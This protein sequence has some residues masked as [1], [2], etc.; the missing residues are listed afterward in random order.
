MRSA[1]ELAVLACVLVLA[2]AACSPLTVLNG[3]VPDHASRIVPDVAYGE[4]GRRL[5]DIYAP[6]GVDKPPVVVF[7]YGGSWRNGSRADYK[8]VGDAL[9][10]RGIMAVIA[11]YR[12]YPAVSYPD[13]VE[14]SARAVAW[15][16]QHIAEYGGDPAR[17]YVA[18]HSA[19]GY[20]AAMVALDARWL[21]RFGASPAMLRGWIGMA[22]PYDFLPIVAR[23]VKPVFHFPG[24]PPDS[25]PIAHV[26]AAAPPTLLMAGLDDTTV[27]PHRNAEALA[28][29]LQAAHVPVTLV[30]YDRL[31]HAMLAGALARPL[32][33]RAPVLDDL[34]AFVLHPLQQ[35]GRA[36][37]GLARQGAR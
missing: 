9:A 1:L 31:G 33:W 14:D 2:L 36:P 13:F 8:F 7:F 32:R 37:S 12:L 34:A 25:Q 16:L 28:A 4:G 18:G 27:D 24:T 6:P 19:G 29:A 11:D 20:N 23:D 35:A 15:T 17:V 26:S 30:L 5:L 10:S 21:A 3:A 22:G